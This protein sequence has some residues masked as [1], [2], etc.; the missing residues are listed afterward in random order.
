[1][2]KNLSNTSK[3]H[4]IHLSK[5]VSNKYLEKNYKTNHKEHL[6]NFGRIHQFV[7]EWKVKFKILGLSSC[8][9]TKVIL[10]IVV[11]III[12][13]PF[14]QKS[15]NP[16]HLDINF[17]YTIITTHFNIHIQVCIY[18]RRVDNGNLSIMHL[19]RIF[20]PLYFLIALYFKKVLVAI[21][22]T[23]TRSSQ[24]KIM[25]SWLERV[26]H[27]LYGVNHLGHLTSR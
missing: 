17:T 2:S 4:Q 21:V 19:G 5:Y 7:S 27:K 24:K 13:I 10:I 23:A 6:L 11:I 16:P 8:T 14:F 26:S 9:S 18:F 1:M 22:S 3:K 15:N 12:I 20:L 25:F